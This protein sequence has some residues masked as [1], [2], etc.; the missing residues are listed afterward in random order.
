VEGPEGGVVVSR[1][2]EEAVVTVQA[3]E[4]LHVLRAELKVEDGT[5]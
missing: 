1:E 2:R 3:L 5:G 4:P